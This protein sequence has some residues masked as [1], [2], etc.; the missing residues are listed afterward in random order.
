M[1]VRSAVVACGVLLTA[2]G[3][4]SY[5]AGPSCRLFED[6][7]GDTFAV[8]SQDSAGAYGPQEDSLDIV[9]GDLA[10]DGT[11][12]SAVIRVNKLAKSASTSPAGLSFRVQFVAPATATDENLWLS[13]RIGTGEPVFSAGYRAITANLSTKLVDVKGVFDYAANEVRI[14]APLSTFEPRGKI[15]TGDKLSIADLDQ[16]ASRFVAVNPAT[17]SDT[18]AFADVSRGDKTYKVGDKTCAPVGK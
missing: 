18:A 13:A 4:P 12:L 17:S 9:S 3:A 14:W 2:L 7:K 10:S 16:T 15:K 8:R 11:T 6:P 1:R 5:A